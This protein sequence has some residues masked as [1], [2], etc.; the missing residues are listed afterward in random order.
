MRRRA[1][2][3]VAGVAAALFVG[4]AIRVAMGL[5]APWLPARHLDADRSSF[6]RLDANSARLRVVALRVDGAGSVAAELGD[7]V[8]GVPSV[9]LYPR[10]RLAGESSHDGT[11]I[12]EL[13]VPA[14]PEVLVLDRRWA[15]AKQHPQ[16]LMLPL[17]EPIE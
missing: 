3:L 4:I 6:A 13:D 2:W 9:N 7:L 11:V 1:L 10:A 5:A 14:W 8:E 12:V 15:H 17:R 16:G